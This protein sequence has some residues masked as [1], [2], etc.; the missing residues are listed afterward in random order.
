MHTQIEVWPVPEF[1]NWD[2]AVLEYTTYNIHAIIYKYTLLHLYYKKLFKTAESIS[3]TVHL[4]VLSSKMDP[5]EIRF[6][7]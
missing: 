3:N 5:V 4:K 7:R 2:N 1:E 6:I